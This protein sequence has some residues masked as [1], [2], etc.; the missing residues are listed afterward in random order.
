MTATAIRSALTDPPAG[1]RRLLSGLRPDGHPT[2]L[3]EHHARY[4]PL[5]GSV[6]LIE[7]ADASG[8]RGRGGGG[9]PT[10][11]KL[12]AVAQQRGRP[13]V[14]VN[15]AEGEPASGKDKALLRLAP[16][17]V[18]DGAFAAAAA[19]GAREIVVAIARDAR[20]ERSSIAAALAERRDRMRWRVASVPAGFIVGEETA[21]LASLAGRPA[22][23][24]L[25][26]PYP[27]ERGL[28]GAPTSSRTSRPSPQLALIARYGPSWFRALGTPAEPGTALVSV[29]GAVARPGVYEI[30]L[31]STLGDLVAQARG[32]TEPIDAYLIGGYFGGWTR[33]T[34]MPLTAASGLGAGIVVAL[35]ETTCALAESAR[36]VRYLAGQSAG[37]CGPCVHGLAALAGG[38]EQLAHGCRGADRQRLA[39]WTREVTGRG[40]CRHPDGAAGFVASSLAT[41]TAE[42]ATHL[43]YGRCRHRD[44]RTLPVGA[45]A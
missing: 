27:F 13:I 41:F 14:V 32:A 33:E 12:R 4:G 3:Q 42:T 26:P 35:P 5:P 10:A 1:T 34:N 17:L 38:L 6:D 11:A 15:G 18:L 37:Q 21:L 19:V 7:L 25:K 20:R 2:R 23:P 28:R 30:E 36:V 16:H 31:G 39:R 9:F 22:K 44:R 45:A 43:Q 24:T 40:A 29:S 8:L